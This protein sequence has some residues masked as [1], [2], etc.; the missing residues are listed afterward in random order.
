MVGSPASLVCQTNDLIEGVLVDAHD[1]YLRGTQ[2]T[3]D[4]PQLINRDN[5]REVINELHLDLHAGRYILYGGES[6]GASVVWRLRLDDDT[7][8]PWFH[9]FDNLALARLFVEF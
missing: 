5:T 6:N 4:V 1:L 2:P 3:I 8:L 7:Y 9:L